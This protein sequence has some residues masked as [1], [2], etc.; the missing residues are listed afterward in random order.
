MP[1]S[2]RPSVDPRAI[3]AVMAGAV[4]GGPARYALDQALPNS[5]E[6]FPW[7]TFTV[8]LTGSLA[9]GLLLVVVF[10]ST[11]SIRHLREFAGVGLL[12]S[13]TTFSTWMVELREQA[14]ASAW[15]VFA[16]YLTGSLVLGLAAAAL[17]ATAGRLAITRRRRRLR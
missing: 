12:G 1:R 17:G 4:I 10:E 14:A 13:F 16:L 8:N 6:Q 9:L 11:W 3:A 2:H 5:P 15:W 7:A